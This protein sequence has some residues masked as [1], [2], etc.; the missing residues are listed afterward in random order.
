M[1][2]EIIDLA[3]KAVLLVLGLLGIWLVGWL[4]DALKARVES[5]QATQLD[6]LIYD[7]VAAAEQTLKEGDPDGSKRKAYVTENLMALGIAISQEINA[8]IEAAVFG[9]N[10]EQK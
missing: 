9:I 7:F 8:R 1:T 3:A 4:K 10:L 5:E 6:R 2:P